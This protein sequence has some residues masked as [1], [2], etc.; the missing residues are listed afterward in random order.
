M[1]IKAKN[2]EMLFKVMAALAVFAVCFFTPILASRIVT[3][4]ARNSVILTDMGNLKNWAEIYE[5]KNGTY[6]GLGEDADIRRMISD[7]KAQGGNCVLSENS[8]DYCARTVFKEIKERDWCI[9]S[10]GYSGKG[11]CSAGTFNCY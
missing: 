7:I 1:D 4:A 5:L 6:A 8:K 11:L 3:K 9:D 10:A 2:C